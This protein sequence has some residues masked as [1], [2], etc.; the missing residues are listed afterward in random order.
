MQQFY[1]FPKTDFSDHLVKLIRLHKI[2]SE[3]YEPNYLVN[4]WKLVT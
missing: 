4:F 2:D 1:S 3:A